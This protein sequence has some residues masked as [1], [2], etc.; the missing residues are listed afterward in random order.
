MDA[1][2]GLRHPTRAPRRKMGPIISAAAQAHPFSIHYINSYVVN[3][4][5]RCGRRPP[6]II[7]KRILNRG[8]HQYAKI[9]K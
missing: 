1:S 9:E 8:H 6:F 4:S 2:D 7:K 5:T 3:S